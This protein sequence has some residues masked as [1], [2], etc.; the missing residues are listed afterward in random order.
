MGRHRPRH[1]NKEIE[2]AL[3]YAEAPWMAGDTAPRSCLGKDCLPLNDQDCRCGAFCQESVWST[4]RVPEH[5]A[6]HIRRA[7]DGCARL[8]GKGGGDG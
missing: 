5:V 1:P 7:L 3:S 4:R 6:R 2:A 8:T